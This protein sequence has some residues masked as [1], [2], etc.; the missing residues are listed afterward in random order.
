VFTVRHPE[1]VSCDVHGRGMTIEDE[2]GSHL[3]EMLLIE[4]METTVAADPGSNTDGPG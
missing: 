2:Q 1:L 4:G 3:V